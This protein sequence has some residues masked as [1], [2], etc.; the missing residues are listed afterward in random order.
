MRKLISLLSLV[1]VAATLQATE[2]DLVTPSGRHVVVTPVTD[3]IL[4][5]ETSAV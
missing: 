4:R 3:D 1:S 5:V 2:I